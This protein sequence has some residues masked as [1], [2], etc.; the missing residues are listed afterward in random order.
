MSSACWKM[1]SSRLLPCRCARKQALR[2]IDASILPAAT[3]PKSSAARART[4]G[5]GPPVT[6]VGPILFRGVYSF[7]VRQVPRLSFT[8]RSGFL[9]K[10]SKAR[11]GPPPTITGIRMP[12]THSSLRSSSEGESERGGESSACLPLRRWRGP[13]SA[14][15]RWGRGLPAWAEGAAHNTW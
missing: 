8:R 9:D 6:S 14:P 11:T 3:S 5:G 10:I 4:G 13:S 7:I 12:L 2:F 1:V 15:W